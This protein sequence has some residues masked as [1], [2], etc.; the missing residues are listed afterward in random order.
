VRASG[1]TSNSRLVVAIERRTKGLLDVEHWAELPGALPPWRLD[2]GAGARDGAEPEHVRR[3]R[4]RPS[5][6]RRVEAD[7]FKD[8]IPAALEGREADR[9]TGPGGVSGGPATPG[10]SAGSGPSAAVSADAQP[11]QLRQLDA[12]VL[13]ADSGIDPRD[14]LGCRAFVLG[15]SAHG[16]RARARSARKASGSCAPLP[17]PAVRLFSSHD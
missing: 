5:A 17:R 12:E 7:P 4:R 15:D 13:D 8:E 3:C 6:R 2:Q 1:R 10:H 11:L 9:S 16:G 14:E